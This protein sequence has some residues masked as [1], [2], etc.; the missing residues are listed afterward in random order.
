MAGFQ[1]SVLNGLLLSLLAAGPVFCETADALYRKGRRAEWQGRHIEAYILYNRARALDPGNAAFV[2]AARRVR[3][4]AAQLMA[5]AGEHRTAIRM[6]PDSWEF[7]HLPGD[8]GVK[9]SGTEPPPTN[10]S[11]RPR[12]PVRLRFRGHQASFRFRGT[13]R[14]AYEE[15]AGEFGLRVLFHED[16]DTDRRVRADL[17][18]CDFRCAMRALGAVSNAVGM[19]VAPDLMLVIEDSENARAAVETSALATVPLD[20]SLSA[21]DIS[22]FSQ[23]IQQTLDI[24]RL[25]STVSGDALFLRGPLPKIDMAHALAD[26]LLRPRGSAVI[27]FEIITVSRGSTVRAGIHLP[28]SFPVTNFSTL[29]G[30][31][32]AADGAERLVGFGGGSTVLGVAVGDAS[33]EARLD[34]SEGRSVHSAQV[35]TGHGLPAE[36]KVGESFPITTAQYSAGGLDIPDQ[37]SRNYVQPPPTVTFEDLGLNLSVTPLIHSAAE[38]TLLM[39]VAF[40]FLSGSAVNGIPVFANREFQ[41]RVRLRSGQFAIVSGTA[42]YERRRL[43]GGLG[44]LGNLPLLGPIFRR[45]ERTWSQRDLLVLVRPRVVTLPPGELVRAR[46]FLFGS[47]ERPVPAL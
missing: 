13:V 32:P 42:V 14:E 20:A 27:E 46:E 36:F 1:S 4:G 41:S 28:S 3:R 15:I 18:E 11:P 16:L 7:Q 35:R 25:A 23:G 17:S 33:V 8:T 45:N 39:E 2:G 29:F 43:G 47:E 24:R 37:G 12:Q 5:V 34:A 30:A 38:V 19:P 22:Q 10:F 40:R 44:G 31:M 21:E 6:A 26:N 9:P